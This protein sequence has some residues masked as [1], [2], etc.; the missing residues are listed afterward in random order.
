M[1]TELIRALQNTN[2][3]DIKNTL[4]IINNY[5]YFP[6]VY[7]EEDISVFNLNYKHSIQND[8]EEEQDQEF[9]YIKIDEDKY[10]ISRNQLYTKF[11]IKENKVY[12][13]YEEDNKKYEETYMEHMTKY[14][15]KYL[16]I[17]DRNNTFTV[18][19]IAEIVN[20]NKFI[21]K[22]NKTIN[23]LCRLQ[24]LSRLDY[25]EICI[26]Y[27]IICYE[28]NIDEIEDLYEYINEVFKD[29]LKYE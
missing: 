13:V 9:Y 3:I 22:V 10:I 23:F 26:N 5:L 1:E 8:E 7:Q 17:N 28:Y 12:K 27:F 21:N 25:I 6:Y 16:F 18:Y 11:I 19:D 14:P 4:S 24:R 20:K 15:E 2:L 29:F